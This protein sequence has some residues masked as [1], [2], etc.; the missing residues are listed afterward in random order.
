MQKNLF[1][2][3]GLIDLFERYKEEILDDITNIDNIEVLLGG[4]HGKGLMTF[5]AVIIVRYKNDNEPT[6]MELQLAQVNSAKDT[7]LL[8]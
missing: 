6:E 8:L 3:R 2:Y 7:M 1:F 4:D 5:M